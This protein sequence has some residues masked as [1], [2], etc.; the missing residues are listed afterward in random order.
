LTQEERRHQSDMLQVYKILSGHM[1]ADQRFKMAADRGHRKRRNM[2]K[3][4]AN[5]EVLANFFSVRAVDSR[6]G[7]L[8]EKIK[9]AKTR[10]S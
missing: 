9:M 4:R 10:N 6:N 1:R 3:P 7:F 5:L 2:I 8:P